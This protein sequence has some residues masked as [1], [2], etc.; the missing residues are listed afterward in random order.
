MW[1]IPGANVHMG[2]QMAERLRQAIAHGSAVGKVPDVTISVGLAQLRNL[3][4]SLT[5]FSRADNA[6]YDA[7]ESGRNRVRLAA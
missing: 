2:E 5:L 3:D 1:I 4:T 7:K 6:L